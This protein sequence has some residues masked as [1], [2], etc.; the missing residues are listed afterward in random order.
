MFFFSFF[1][2]L[3]CEKDIN[4]E[5]GNRYAMLC[6]DVRSEKK[7][8]ENIYKEIKLNN[9]QGHALNEKL[10]NEFSLKSWK[11][12]T[13]KK[14]YFSFWDLYKTEEKRVQTRRLILK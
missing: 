12:K 11:V 13:N 9:C 6:D 5:K 7:K 14:K 1:L 2:L 4:D 8:N 10:F 3:K